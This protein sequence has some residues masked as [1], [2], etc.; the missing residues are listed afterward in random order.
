MEDRFN[1]QRFAF[2]PADAAVPEE[3]EPEPQTSGTR[4]SMLQPQLVENILAKN[5]SL[6]EIADRLA[7]KAKT[8]GTIS[9]YSG[10]TEKFR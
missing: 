10:M 3:G 2:Q 7:K 8:S 4:G 6:K 5:Q 9:N 1:L